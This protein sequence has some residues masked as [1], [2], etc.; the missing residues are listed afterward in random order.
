MLLF[1]LPALTATPIGK[2][3]RAL[4]LAT[5]TELAEELELFIELLTELEL[6]LL[7]EE[8]L[9]TDELDLI[10]DELLTTDELDLTDEELLTTDELDLMDE[11]LLTTE[12]E[13]TPQPATT[14][15][16]AG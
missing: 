12:L 15:K 10:D 16:G 14:P 9:T 7:E 11:E 1:S 2:L 6:S 13:D 4:R 8:L 3:A 5:P